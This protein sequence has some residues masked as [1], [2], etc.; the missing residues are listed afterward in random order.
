MKIADR[1]TVAKVVNGFF[2]GV[3]VFLAAVPFV[4]QVFFT[5]CHLI[6][7]AVLTLGSVQRDGSAFAGELE[8]EG[9]VGGGGHGKG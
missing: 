3:E 7:C 5:G 6:G 9:V 2:E 1:V 8:E 4:F